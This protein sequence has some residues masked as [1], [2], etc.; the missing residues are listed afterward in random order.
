MPWNVTDQREIRWEFVQA[1]LAP[2]DGFAGVCRRFNISRRCGYKWWGRFKRGGRDALVAGTSRSAA[3]ERLQRRWLKR[4]IALRRQR[5]TWGPQKLQWLL[6]EHYGGPQLPGTRTIGRWLA[7]AGLRRRR[8]R[9]ARLGPS[10]SAPRPIV[11]ARSNDVWT[12]DF[13]GTFRTTDRTRIFP[14]TVRDLATRCV[15]VVRHLPEPTECAVRAIL[16]RLFRQYGLPRAVWVDNGPPFGGDGALGLSRLS[17]WWL[18]LGLQVEFSR[19]AC[20]QDNPGHEQMH[21]ILKAETARP[22]AATAASQQRRFHRWRRHY[23]HERPHAA[24]GQ[25]TPA[26]FYRS[27]VRRL[28]TSIPTWT[29]PRLWP[30]LYPDARGRCSW[31]DRQRVI[32]RAFAGEQLALRVRAARWAEVYLGPHLIGTLHADDVAGMRPAKWIRTPRTH[33]HY[34]QTAKNRRGG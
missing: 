11:P 10:V 15:L 32:G 24:L 2:H 33:R 19:P 30:R 3:A 29:Y 17:V 1:M 28:P 21:R 13:K 6:G 7:Q 25:R 20:P 27:S 26:S 22:P 4:V 12:L 9:R 8:V 5:P 18:R 31:Q 16:A 14:L 34:P 23:N